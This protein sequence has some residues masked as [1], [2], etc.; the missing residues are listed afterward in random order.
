MY[1]NSTLSSFYTLHDM[2]QSFCDAIVNFREHRLQNW[3]V[4]DGF[5][6]SR[7]CK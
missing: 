6:A 5:Y 7:K 1:I 2:Y 4:G 3:L